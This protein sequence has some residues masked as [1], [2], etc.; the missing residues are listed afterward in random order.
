MIDNSSF[1]KHALNK[2][3]GVEY[4]ILDVFVALD[5]SERGKEEIYLRMDANY[6]Q[7]IIDLGLSLY[8]TFA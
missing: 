8:I 4:A 5:E 6:L 7:K 3:K 1:S 2:I